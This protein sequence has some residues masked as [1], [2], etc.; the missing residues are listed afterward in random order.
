[1]THSGNYPPGTYICRS[2][3]NEIYAWPYTRNIDNLYI[4]LLK[5]MLLQQSSYGVD[6]RVCRDF[7]LIEL[8]TVTVHTM[9]CKALL[10]HDGR[11]E[12]QIYQL[13]QQT[14]L[15]STSNFGRF[16]DEVRRLAP[17]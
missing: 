10:T 13:P 17:A 9:T 4:H 7:S 1:M 16:F 12:F 14:P 15:R 2:C 5:C 11:R 8:W 6:I 3:H